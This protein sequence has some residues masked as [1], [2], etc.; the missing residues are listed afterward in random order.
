MVAFSLSMPFSYYMGPCLPFFPHHAICFFN[1]PFMHQN[2]TLLLRLVTLSLS[3]IFFHYLYLLLLLN[4]GQTL[5]FNSHHLFLSSHKFDFLL[6]HLS[7][8]SCLLGSPHT[9]SLPIHRL[10]IH[11]EPDCLF[12]VLFSVEGMWRGMFRCRGGSFALG[13]QN[14]QHWK[15][16][17]F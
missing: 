15:L 7:I 12:S 11:R 8:V 6:L 13:I 10:T 3:A 5:Q 14:N 4:I 9:S 16:N 17:M 1:H 2:E